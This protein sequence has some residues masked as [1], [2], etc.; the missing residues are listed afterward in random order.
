[1][2]ASEL[3]AIMRA[4]LVLGTMRH[5]RTST[6]GPAAGVASS[7]RCL[8]TSGAV[9]TSAERKAAARVKAAARLERRAER[10]PAS[11][12]R[13]KASFAEQE[14][15]LRAELA[16]LSRHLETLE[17]NE[18]SDAH[19][20]AQG[21][22]AEPLDDETLDQLYH[23][24]MAPAPLS[25]EEQRLEKRD[26]LLRARERGRAL[27]PPSPSPSAPLPTRSREQMHIDRL[28]V[29]FTRLTLPAPQQDAQAP[30]E[31]L[32]DMRSNLAQRIATI[33]QQHQYPLHT[34]DREH[35][36]KQ[37]QKQEQATPKQDDLNF[38]P[39]SLSLQPAA[40]ETANEQYLAAAQTAVSDVSS[41][42]SRAVMFERLERLLPPEHDGRAT[43]PL[44]IATLP[45]WR[46]LAVSC[47]SAHDAAGVSRVYSLMQRSG[48]PV[49]L[50]LYNDVMD[51]Y[52]TRGE[53]ALVQSTLVSLTQAGHAPDDHT[54]HSLTKAYLTAGHVADALRLLNSLEA[55]PSPAPASMATYTL[56]IDRL[57]DHPSV[58]IRTLGWNLFYH[59]R[60]VAHPVPDAP[61]YARMI[62]ACAQ[63]TPPSP[64]DPHIVEAER[65]LDL[66]REMTTRYNVRPNAEVYNN[67]IAAC[68]RRKD[69]YLDAF[70]LLREM[71]EL[72]HD[73]FAPDT[74]TFN[75]LL[76][77]CAKNRDLPRARWVL[78]E[79][80]RTSSAGTGAGP[81]PN[82]E[83]MANVFYAYA[84][85]EPPKRI[86]AKQ[87]SAEGEGEAE[88]EAGSEGVAVAEVEAAS[89]FTSAIPGTSGEVLG[90]ARALLARIVHD[91]AGGGGVM[92]GVKVTTHLLNAYL[93]V[94]AAHGVASLAV[95]DEL[96]VDANEH[97]Y[98][99]MLETAAR[100]RLVARGDQTSDAMW[101]RLHLGPGAGAGVARRA[102]AARIHRL[103]K[104]NRIPE[105]MR[106]LREFAA[107]FP[108]ATKRD[109][110]HRQAQASLLPLPAD[111][112][113]SPLPVDPASLTALADPQHA[114]TPSSTPPS[115]S[116]V[117]LQLLHHRLVRTADTHN[118]AYL[119][120]LTHAYEHS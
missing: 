34:Q 36:Q 113:L 86:K 51:V 78:A 2:Y 12:S 109:R 54:H 53:L 98:V 16:A 37:E 75:A 22:G 46:A 49:P 1:M 105:A 63:A 9:S 31:S 108:P 38:E 74:Y 67:L 92:A 82:D 87:G 40:T 45:E 18:A 88:A 8:H 28:Q 102:Y 119:N 42:P 66:F 68:A 116:F 52:A 103:A 70:R 84:S 95:F 114:P 77:G 23:A 55:S 93:S 20:Q 89:V 112:D 29:L 107:R 62:R 35:K 25:A 58:P 72:D 64:G 3:S 33:L 10:L 5:F 6:V 76:Q 47:A 71:V 32:Q 83:T 97:S 94:Q 4:R 11:A 30:T 111:I 96:G 69:F 65:A 110:Q 104:S 59:M 43:L 61:L 19:A 101:A 50:A 60:L 90:E 48:T 13:P 91:S 7:S 79:M 120:W 99:V 106:T 80:I 39:L 100:D 24:L 73:R 26:R 14:K 17:K 27:L 41:A 44:G 85:F 56:A 57:L 81:M 21:A 117:D 15:I 115:L 118:L